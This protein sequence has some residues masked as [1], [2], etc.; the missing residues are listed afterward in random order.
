M[1]L[2]GGMPGPQR[3]STIIG[4]VTGVPLLAQACSD[5]PIGYK[6]PRVWKN[7]IQENRFSAMNRPTAGARTEEAL[8]VGFGG[9]CM[10][11]SL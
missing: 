4:Q 2:L 3:V 7:E 1:L 10:N 11:T 5:D 8:P 6:P 9:K